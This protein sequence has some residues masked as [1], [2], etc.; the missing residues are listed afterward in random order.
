MPEDQGVNGD[1]WTKQAAELLRRLG[2]EKVAD[3]NIDIEGNDGLL[4]GI[5]ALFKYEDGARLTTEGVFLEAKNYATTSFNKAKI[6]DWV[7]KLDEKIDSLSKSS[8]FYKDFPAMAE[9]KSRNGLLILWF[10]DVKKF[11]DFKPKL[12]QAMASVVVPRARTS[13]KPNRLFVLANNDILRLSALVNAVEDWNSKAK[14]DENKLRFVYPSNFKNPVQQ[15]NTL[16]LEYMYSKFVLAR[17][18]DNIS[19][20]IKQSDIVFYFGKHN[21]DSYKRLRDGL[22][23]MRMIAQNHHFFIYQY[24]RD[25]DFRKIQPDVEKLFRE[26]GYPDVDFKS[27]DQL[28]DLP[29]WMADVQ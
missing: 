1:R 13:R 29:S 6:Q 5:D 14:G 10:S 26:Q 27:M 4:H 17:A 15:R 2:W 21:M 22:L 8:E 20:M 19:G 28:A 23:S 11:E 3:S 24:N 12:E 16:N 9:T 25:K 7:T 18:E